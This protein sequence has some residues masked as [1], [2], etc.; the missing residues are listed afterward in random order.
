MVLDR[1]WFR[2][3]LCGDELGTGVTW[4]YRVPDQSR[5]GGSD[6]T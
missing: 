1:Q 5:G 2:T 4:L 6:D 3:N